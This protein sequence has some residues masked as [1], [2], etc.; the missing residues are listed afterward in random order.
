[1]VGWLSPGM[2]VVWKL[3]GLGVLGVMRKLG[4]YVYAGVGRV[5]HYGGL[6]CPEV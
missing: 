1:M 5:E 3:R 2:R 6:S 4:G